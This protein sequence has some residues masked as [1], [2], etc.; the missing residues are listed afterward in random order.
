MTPPNHYTFG[1][2]ERAARRLLLLAQAYDEPSRALIE[3]FRGDG[4][5]L[6]LD[7]G[8]GP[9]H[10]TRLLHEVSRAARTVGVDASPRYVEQARA[11]APPGVEFLVHDLLRAPYPIEPAPLVFCRFFMTHVADPRGAITSFRGLVQT[12]GRLLLQETSELACPHPAFVR[13]YEQVALLQRHYGQN[14][15]IGRELAGIARDAP[16]ELVHAADR[17]FERPAPVMA[18]LHALNIATWRNDA[19]ARRA[20]EATELEALEA[21]LWAIARGDE[22]AEPVSVGLA[23]V[24]LA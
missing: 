24:V 15:Y 14:L 2:S 4:P 3:R 9:G 19:F 22:A 10:T 16:F 23:E 12:G 8:S 18:E 17:R 13:Y 7:L 11:A 6:A 1:D 21:R 20:F 5:A